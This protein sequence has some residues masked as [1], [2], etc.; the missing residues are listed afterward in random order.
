MNNIIFDGETAKISFV[1][2]EIDERGNLYI[3]FKSENKYDDFIHVYMEHICLDD[4]EYTRGSIGITALTEGTYE[5]SKIEIKKKYLPKAAGDVRK[6]R[7]LLQTLDRFIVIE[8]KEIAILLGKASMSYE[9]KF[10]SG[11]GYLDDLNQSPKEEY[12]NQ[13]SEQIQKML[14]TSIEAVVS[15]SRKCGETREQII[16]RLTQIYGFTADA[17][18]TKLISYEKG[19]IKN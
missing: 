19:E 2:T 7:F 9:K 14:E 1:G 17:A 3:W 18:E 11:I 10:K 5:I 8:E 15:L 4:E 16:N 13:S 6:L 12:E